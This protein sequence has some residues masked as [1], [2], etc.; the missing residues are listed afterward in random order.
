MVE[1]KLKDCSMNERDINSSQVDNLELNEL[2]RQDV[3]INNNDVFSSRSFLV[4]RRFLLHSNFSRNQPSL[5]TTITV[6]N[7]D[8]FKALAVAL[9]EKV[10]LKL[11]YYSHNKK[12]DTCWRGMS[13]QLCRKKWRSSRG[14]YYS[15]EYGNDADTHRDSEA[16]FADWRPTNN[17][18]FAR[19][20]IENA[21]LKE[22]LESMEHLIRAVIGGFA[23][24]FLS[25]KSQLHPK[26][27]R[28]APRIEADSGSFSKRVE[29]EIDNRHSTRENMDFVSA[30]GFEM[31][32]LLVFVT[33]LLKEYKCS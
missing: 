2:E 20:K 32:E 14:T 8:A 3:R 25:L 11:Y 24:H 9:N 16:N 23:F 17:M 1:E 26:V 15:A 22:S 7:S 12:K 30:T 33:Q 18:D 28:T 19:M 27:W 10:L 29:G 13:M 31:V 6:G 5:I 4:I 21:T